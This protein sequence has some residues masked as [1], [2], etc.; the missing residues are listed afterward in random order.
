[1]T[2]DVTEWLARIAI[3]HRRDQIATFNVVQVSLAVLT[4]YSE[5]NHTTLACTTR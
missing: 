5:Q 1:V 4:R 3:I 2:P